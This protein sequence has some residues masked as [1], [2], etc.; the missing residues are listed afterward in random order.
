M[1]PALR[2]LNLGCGNRPFSGA[3]VVNHDRISH[4]PEIS[5]AWDLNDL[6]WPW[7][8]ASFDVIA[9]WACLEHLSHDLVVSFDECWRILKVGGQLNV[10][11]PYWNHEHSFNDPTHRWKFGLGVFDFFDPETRDGQVY[12]FYTL[13]K[14]KVLWKGYCGGAKCSIA[15]RLEKRA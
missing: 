15:A 4:R 6:P 11:L 2:I 9:A 5:V 8:D 1:Q 13:R 10:K 14:W 12:A 3:S 7:E